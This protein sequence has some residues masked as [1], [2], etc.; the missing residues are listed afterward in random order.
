MVLCCAGLARPRRRLSELLLKAAVSSTADPSADK[1]LRLLFLRSPISF[2]GTSHVSAVKL[3]V[4]NL[5]G[6]T[7]EV[8]GTYI[9]VTIK[10]AVNHSFGFVS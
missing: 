8:Q 10:S 5:Q 2:L 4:T 9:I 6:D 3:A 7:L 1:A